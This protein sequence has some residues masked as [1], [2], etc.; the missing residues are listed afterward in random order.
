MKKLLSWMV[1]L[2]VAVIFLAPLLWMIRGAFLPEDRIFLRPDLWAGDLSH[3]TLQNIADAWRRTDL[4]QA[5][6]ISL[7]QVT[8]IISVGL[9]LNSMAAFAFARFSF[10][11]RDVLFTLIVA[12]IILPVEVLV[13]PLFLTARDL[14]LTGGFGA[15][16]L[17]LIVPF[18]AKA[19]NIF[20]L[21]QHF[22]SLSPAQEE[23]ALL[24]GAGWF[25]IYFSVALPSIRPALA[26]VIVLDI[27]TH[28]SDFIWPLVVCTRSETR[29]VQIA[30]ANLFTQPPVQWGD[31][32]AC[33]LLL[34]LPVLLFFR[35]AQ[36][37]LV[38]SDMDAG[39]K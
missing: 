31:I 36:R 28:W 8:G 30:L 5:F 21:R 13:I 25:R 39:D 6:L 11:G 17:A 4:G 22:L 23:A 20:F 27:L 34:T 16:M 26:T 29:T 10:R 33:A 24:D 2:S 1:S 12:M 15:V 3:F 18:S 38:V 35:M 14:N 19:M 37:Y 9:L 32:L 7:L